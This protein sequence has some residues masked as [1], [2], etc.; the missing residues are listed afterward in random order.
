MSLEE[1][2]AI[3]RRLFHDAWTLNKVSEMDEYVH[4][5]NVHYY[6]T[7]PVKFGPE[8]MRALVKNWRG[9][10]PDFRYDIEDIIAEGDLVVARVRFMGTQ[11][12][13][14]AIASR[15]LAPSDMAVD[16]AEI[17]IIRVAAGKIVES[18]ATWDRLSVLEQLGAISRVPASS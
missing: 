1:N 4:P 2:K 8:E 3:A 12:G 10:M 9:A 16:E 18:W 17:M 7:R 13:T 5:E 11:T 14:F 15:T 6:G